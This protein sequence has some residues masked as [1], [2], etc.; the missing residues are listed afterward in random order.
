VPEP[1]RLPWKRLPP[2]ADLPKDRPLQA[3]FLTLNGVF[4]SE[5]IAPYD[6]FHHSSLHTKPRPGIEVFTVSPDGKQVTTFEGLKFTPDYSF[7][8][9]PDIDI[10]VVPSGAQSLGKD[11]DNREMIGWLRRVGSKARYVVSL[12]DAAFVLAFAGLLDG[13]ACTTFPGDQGFFANMFPRLDLRRGPTFVHDGRI[14]TSE[15]GARSYL[16]ALYLLDYL[17][18]EEVARKVGVGLVIPWPLAVSALPVAV[19]DPA[20]RR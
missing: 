13:H 16:V 20:S 19:I 15:G 17:Y 18:G 2:P 12:C 1:V 6:V 3:G 14:L 11:L 10:L 4:D 8:N 5:L 9:A 7:A